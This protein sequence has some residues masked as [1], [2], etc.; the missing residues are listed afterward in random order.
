[1]LYEVITDNGEEIEIEKRYDESGRLI[2]SGPFKEGK[3][4][5]IHREYNSDGTVRDAKIYND[6]GVLISEGVRNNFV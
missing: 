4:V 2:Y 6:N 1:M 3:P 5:G